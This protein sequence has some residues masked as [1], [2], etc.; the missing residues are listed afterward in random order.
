K[1]TTTFAWQ[2]STGQFEGMQPIG[3][4]LLCLIMD[5]VYWLFWKQFCVN[6]TT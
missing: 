3:V 2:I 5:K 6:I 1:L 4:K